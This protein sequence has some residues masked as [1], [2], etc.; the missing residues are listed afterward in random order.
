MIKMEGFGYRGEW[1]ETPDPQAY[2]RDDEAGRAE[3]ERDMAAQLEFIERNPHR[4][5]PTWRPSWRGN[6]GPGGW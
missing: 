3:R 1:V 4:L 5:G 6:D 2:R